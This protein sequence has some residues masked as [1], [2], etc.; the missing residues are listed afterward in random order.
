MRHSPLRCLFILLL[1]LLAATAF[2]TPATDPASGLI[3]HWS[4]ADRL[5]DGREIVVETTI[6]AD[7]RFTGLARLAGETVWT[8]AGTWQLEDR[9]LIWEYVESSKPLPQSMKT[10][11]DEIISASPGALVLRSTRTGKLHTFLRRD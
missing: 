5:P 7:A 8:Y 10:D 4:A 11:V 2:A 6:A 1:P 3:G 9:R